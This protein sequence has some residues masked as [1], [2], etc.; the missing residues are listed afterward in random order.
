MDY[1][2][3]PNPSK[4]MHM[5]N[6]QATI[7]VSLLS[8]FS[9]LFCELNIC[10]AFPI[11]AMPS[12]FGECIRISMISNNADITCVVQISFNKIVLLYIFG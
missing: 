9:A 1:L 7:A 10:A 11:P 8:P 12:P 5:M 4:K 3:I 6:T 2:T